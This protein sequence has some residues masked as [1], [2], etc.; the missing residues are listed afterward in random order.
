VLVAFGAHDCRWFTERYDLP[1]QPLH[2]LGERL[3]AFLP[4]P[5]SWQKKTFGT[6]YSDG[7]L[8]RLRVALA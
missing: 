3:L 8:V 6:V 1:D 4:H 2:D 5:T 7:D